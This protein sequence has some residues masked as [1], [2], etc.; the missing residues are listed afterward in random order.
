MNIRFFPVF[1]ML[2]LCESLFAQEPTLLKTQNDKVNYGIG[3]GIARNFQRQGMNVDVELVVKGMKDTLSGGTLLMTEEDLMT[4]MTVFQQELIKR[5]TEAT[6]LA[7]EKNKI[8]GEAFL[9]E[10]AKKEGITVLPSG[11]QYKVLKTGDGKK[12]SATDSVECNYVGTFIDGKEFDNSYKVGKA[13]TLKVDGGVIPGWS[14]A[15]K[16][17]PVGSKWQIFIPSQLAYGEKGAGSQIGPNMTLVFE[18]DLLGIK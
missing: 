6:K 14:E 15:L 11:L 13:I 4:T 17:M 2:L 3:V 8:E 12:P 7:A 16:L 18:I 5:L 9:A 10:N 1:A